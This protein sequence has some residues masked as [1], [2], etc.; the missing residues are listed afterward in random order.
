MFAIVI[1]ALLRPRLPPRKAG[2]IIEL[3]AFLEAPYTL[4][5]IGMFFIFLGLYFAFFYINSYATSVIGTSSETAATLLVIINAIT[6]PARPLLGYISDRWVHPLLTT[7]A[8]STLLACMLFLWIPVKTSGGM[9]AWVVVYGFAT[10]GTQGMFSGGL[11]S[12]TR[13]PAKMG[14]RFGMVCSILAFATLAGAPI[15][16]ALIENMN[17]SYVG[18][19]CWAGAVT[20]VGA[21]FF[22]ASWWSDRKLVR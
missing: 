9:Y 16:G 7:A 6:I 10:G 22:T 17:G 13:D 1:L 2:P 5:T 12:L 8:A 11:A 20:L 4:F 15:A 3:H 19:Q 21:L 14:T 18:A